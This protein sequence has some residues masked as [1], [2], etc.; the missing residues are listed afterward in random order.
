MQKG[1]LYHT[2]DPNKTEKWFETAQYSRK[3]LT[4]LFKEKEKLSE[5]KKEKSLA[6]S[7]KNE[8]V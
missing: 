6:K 3:K 2:I 5:E 7:K 1:N 4:Q 8:Y